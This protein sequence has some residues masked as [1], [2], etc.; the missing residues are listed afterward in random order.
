M[1]IRMSTIPFEKYSWFEELAE[2]IENP[3]VLILMRAA[4]QSKC[5]LLLL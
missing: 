2:I 1:I 4:E 3:V 5:S